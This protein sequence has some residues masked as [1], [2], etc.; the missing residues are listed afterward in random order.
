MKTSLF[1]VTVIV[2]AQN[3]EANISYCIESVVGW[4]EQVF[5]V[6]SFSIDRTMLI[7]KTL[8]AAIYQNQFIDWASQ[9]NWALDNLPIKTN[10]VFFLDADEVVTEAFKLE[11]QQ[12]ISKASP[13]LAA[14][15]V[16]FDF[17][18]LGRALKYAYEA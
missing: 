15:Y 1:P 14:F 3:E 17:I 5:V 13:E 7:A 12:A 4:A 18:F 11:T 8:G 10:W 16:Y 2:I 6:D 9:R